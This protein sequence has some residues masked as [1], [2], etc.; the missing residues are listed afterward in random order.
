[1]RDSAA[2]IFRKEQTLTFDGVEFQKKCL[3]YA[4]LTSPLRTSY[5]LN[6]PQTPDFKDFKS[7]INAFF[8]N[9]QSYSQEIKTFIDRKSVV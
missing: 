5:A 8:D 2:T 1:M 9:I 6:E 4:D 3:K 7:A